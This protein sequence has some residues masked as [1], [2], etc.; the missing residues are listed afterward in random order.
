MRCTG[1]LE[2]GSPLFAAWTDMTGYRGKAA[3]SLPTAT[4]VLSS[5]GPSISDIFDHRVEKKSSF[6]FW[7]WAAVSWHHS[8]A[9][10]GAACALLCAPEL[11]PLTS[12]SKSSQNEVP[13]LLQRQHWSLTG[14]IWPICRLQYHE[15]QLW[16]LPISQFCWGTLDLY[17]VTWNRRH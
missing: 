14:T 13:R 8:T 1:S 9:P 6:P 4:Q 17:T 16:I 7:G 10:A 12:G 5:T 11:R 3:P 15:A 2:T